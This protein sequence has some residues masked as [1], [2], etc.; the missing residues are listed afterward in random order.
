MASAVSLKV[1][2][3]LEFLPRSEIQSPARARARLEVAA[4]GGPEAAGYYAAAELPSL[5][6]SVKIASTFFLASP[7]S[8]RVP[9]LKKSGFSTPA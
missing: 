6:R 2:A 8:M 3:A 1:Q 7:N 4:G 5:R 9:S